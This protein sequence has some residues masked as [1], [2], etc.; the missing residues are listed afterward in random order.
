MRLDGKGANSDID[1]C[2]AFCCYGA[3]HH[4]TNC[5]DI[6]CLDSIRFDAANNQPNW[7][8]L[9]SKFIAKVKVLLTIVFL[10]L[11][12]TTGVPF[13]AQAQFLF[14]L[15]VPLR[16]GPMSYK[17]SI[18]AT[19]VVVQAVHCWSVRVRLPFLGGVGESVGS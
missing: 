17:D 3:R 6:G 1:R 18:V 2:L 13:L 15:V 10:L 7:T 14:E 9:D 12:D 16:R 11:M 4:P 5:P 8:L 19:M